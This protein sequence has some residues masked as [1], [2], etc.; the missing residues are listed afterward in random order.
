M[1]AGGGSDAEAEA[2]ASGIKAA[3]EAHAGVRR[4]GAALKSRA[5]CAEAAAAT[6]T[7]EAERRA[8]KA[9]TEAEILLGGDLGPLGAWVAEDAHRKAE[10]QGSAGGESERDRLG[11]GFIGAG[12]D[13][14]ESAPPS[15]GGIGGEAGWIDWTS[16]KAECGLGAVGPFRDEEEDASAP[17]VDRGVAS[18]C[19]EGTAGIED[20]F[21]GVGQAFEGVGGADKLG[22]A[23]FGRFVGN[24]GGLGSGEDGGT[25]RA[26]TKVKGP[27]T[28][29]APM[30]GRLQTAT[31]SRTPSK[32]TPAG[33]STLSRKQAPRGTVPP[34]ATPES[35]AGPEAT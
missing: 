15:V 11:G 22:D 14:I 7:A 29:S 1:V 25:I 6:G 19:V 17:D 10:G 5:A 31:L 18:G 9:P 27:T 35:A 26:D 23:G 32:T 16:L 34:T 30:A 28:R 8:P 21:A 2:V 33:I 13:A 4:W 24:G 12:G 20:D 3:S